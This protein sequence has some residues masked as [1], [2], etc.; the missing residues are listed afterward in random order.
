MKDVGKKKFEVKFRE[1]PDGFKEKAIFIDD[2]KLDY[3]I[4]ISSYLEARQMG[5]VY[6]LAVQRDI[7]KHFTESVSEVLGRKVSIEDIKKAIVTGWI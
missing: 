4:D 5:T 7:E 2:E 6:K 3:S 1:H